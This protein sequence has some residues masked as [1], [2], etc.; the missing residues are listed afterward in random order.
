M[1]IFIDPGHGGES[2]G[3]VYKGRHE[4]DDV[5][6][7]SL[8]ARDIL[9]KNENVEVMLSR[10]GN[11][12]PS[13]EERARMANEW[14]ADYFC[15]VHRNAFLPNKAKGVEAWCYSAVKKGGE[16][17][18]LAEN[19]V[20]GICKAVGFNNRGVKLGAPSYDDFAVNRLT[21]M[22]SCLLEAGFIDSD[23]DNN[24]F[25]SRFDKLS[26]SLAEGLL[27]AVGIE[28]VTVGDVDGDGKLTASDARSVLRA[29]VELENV[30]L[31]K[32]DVNGD[33]KITAADAREILRKSV[34][35]EG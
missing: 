26:S 10:E 23:E 8:A 11:E 25:D 35:G 7:L 19:I 30:P 1:K 17:Y 18:S 2:I 5:L 28:P 34:E 3:A 14:G 21:K 6:R 22:S 24:I 9:I 13:L 29:S 27:R 31:E 20:D 12:N 32:G 16:T 33:G 4:Q 15:S